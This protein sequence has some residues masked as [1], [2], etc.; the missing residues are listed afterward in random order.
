M[1]SNNPQ[2]PAAN[3]SPEVKLGQKRKAEAYQPVDE[4]LPYQRYQAKKQRAESD[5]KEQEELRA[6]FAMQPV[7]PVGQQPQ[8]PSESTAASRA[9]HFTQPKFEQPSQ[10]FTQ[11]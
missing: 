3:K 6:Q 2:K 9:A 11:Q 7:R 8:N 5:R 1:F 4:Q 10:L